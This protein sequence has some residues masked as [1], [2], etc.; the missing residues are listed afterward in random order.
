VLSSACPGSEA[1]VRASELVQWLQKAKKE[2]LAGV[3]TVGK[4]AM[5]PFTSLSTDARLHTLSFLP[6][7]EKFLVARCSRDFRALSV[8]SLRVTKEIN[9]TSFR[10]DEI[11]DAVAHIQ[12]RC[13]NIGAVNMNFLDLCSPSDIPICSIVSLVEKCRKISSLQ[14]CRLKGFSQVSRIIASIAQNLKEIRIL[15]ISYLG[16]WVRDDSLRALGHRCGSLK[17]LKLNGWA[18]S[19]EGWL[20]F[21]KHTQCAVLQTSC[22]RF[23]PI[24]CTI[25]LKEHWKLKQFRHLTLENSKVLDENCAQIAKVFPNLTEI[26]LELNQKVSNVGVVALVQTGEFSRV[27]LRGVAVCYRQLKDCDLLTSQQLM[28]LCGVGLAK[29]FE[30]LRLANFLNKFEGACRRCL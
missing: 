15:D 17:A 2:T 14:L 27:L 6:F 5:Y 21:L 8:T 30:C 20:E 13:T 3:Q 29:D 26:D 22:A 28:V 7:R 23:F 9:L 25:L 18:V 19:I 16:A 11:V 24:A 10:T 12:S 4:S 1:G